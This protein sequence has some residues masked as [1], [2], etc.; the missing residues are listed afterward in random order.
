[1]RGGAGQPRR[2]RAGRARGIRGSSPGGSGG[3]GSRAELWEAGPR[4]L[5]ASRS[6][7]QPRREC[8]AGLRGA[9][10]RLAEAGGGAAAG[11]RR[12]GLP[13]GGLLFVQVNSAGLSAF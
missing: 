12:C 8:C 4:A 10:G 6:L 7:A 11:R 5:K 3:A 13:S 1:M 9:G 2:A